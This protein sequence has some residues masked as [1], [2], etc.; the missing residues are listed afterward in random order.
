MSDLLMRRKWLL[1]W[2][3]LGTEFPIRHMRWNAHGRA[4]LALFRRCSG[5]PRYDPR[6]QFIDV[7]FRQ[8]VNLPGP[9]VE[10][11]PEVDHGSASRTSVRDIDL[12]AEMVALEQFRP[13]DV[14]DDAGVVNGRHARPIAVADGAGP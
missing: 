4:R 11:V 3:Q 5:Q 9:V 2:M 6:L 10:L 14:S 13:Q 8:H 7:N 12:Q 1:A